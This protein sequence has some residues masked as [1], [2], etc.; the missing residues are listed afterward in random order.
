MIGQTVSHYRVLERLGGGGM[1]VVYKAEDLRLGRLVA[2]KFLPEP[3]SEDEHAIERFRRE[4]RAA[5]A[6]NHPH[7]CTIYEIDECGGRPFIAMELLEGSTLKHKAIKTAEL[8]N[9]AIQ[10]A[11]GLE[12]AH[13][14]GIVHRDIKPANIFLTSRGQIKILDFGLAKLVE[15]RG[16]RRDGSEDSDTATGGPDAAHLTQAGTTL[17]TAAYMSPEQVRGERVDARSDLF[18]FGAVLY[19][20]ATG[21]QAFSGAT[22]PA[23][24]DTILNRMPASPAR[25]NPEL[26]PELERIIQKALEKDAAVRY[27][28]ASDLLADLR[29]L[30]RDAEA[31]PARAAEA[32]E[33]GRRRSRKAIHSVAILPFENASG[34]PEAEYFSDGVTESIISSLSRLPNLKVMARSMVFRY[35]GRALDPR[36]AG[37]E[38][39]VGAVVT[40]RV[41]QRGDSLVIGAELVDVVDGWQLWGAQYNRSLAHVFAVQEE[42]AA[43]IAERLRL[44][45]T[46]DEKKRLSKRYTESISAYQAYLRGRYHWNKRTR[47]SLQKGVESFK[48]ALEEDPAYALAYAGLADSYAL[49]GIAEYGVLPPREAMP[50]AR[51][52]ALRA[53]EIDPALGQAQTQVAHVKAFFEWDWM[54][55]DREFK[56]AIE[57][58]PDYAFAH[59]WYALYLA[60]MERMEEAIA[61][62]K[63]AQE[64]DPL[65]P[66]I[67]KNVG[68]IYYYASRYDQ[69]TAQYRRAL[70]LDP[71]FA[72]TYFFMGLLY[73]QEAM[74]EDAVTA[75]QRAIDLAGDTPV[76]LSALA[77]AYAVSGRR[78]EAEGML[79]TLK[80]RATREYVPAFGVAT[81]YAGLGDKEQAFE[82]LER[83][84]QERSSWLLS[85]KVEPIFA[86]L[87]SEPRFQDLVRRV[88]LPA[89]GNSPPRPRETAR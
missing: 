63:R 70:E 58:T 9:L 69:A 59:H 86:D 25:L 7:I 49:L 68:T 41:I 53:L 82:W 50:K 74:F 16:E 30:H 1:G 15:P 42:V 28:T 61:A 77:H 85:L 34:D 45:L 32:P 71:D 4:A 18:S 21:R 17:G 62:E 87:R 22:L 19:E 26:P 3:M 5:S 46:R 66:V 23:I 84:Y 29:R 78:R 47:D 89:M 55:A 64:L 31:E 6:L 13:S 35:K 67:N 14:E 57:L 11:E 48:R 76:M 38:L 27:Q 43:E 8:L 81:V 88:G 33:T 24:Y 60:A 83:A 65:S 10:V 39:G 12:A 40:G 2:L 73:E 56:R 37:R 44:K 52:A 36:R 51:A 72:R 79:E 75:F 80:E 20:L 54:G